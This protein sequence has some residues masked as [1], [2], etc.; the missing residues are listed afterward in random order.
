MFLFLG[1]ILLPIWWHCSNYYLVFE[2][3]KDLRNIVIVTSIIGVAIW[4]ILMLF[5][6]KIGIYVGFFVQMLLRSVWIYIESRK[7]WN[8]KISYEGVIIGILITYFGYLI[9]G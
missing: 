6:G 8:L 2:R 1:Y 4:L 7:H 9:L 3:G 5:F